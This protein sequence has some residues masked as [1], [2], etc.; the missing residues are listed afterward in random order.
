MK[1]DRFKA[2][3]PLIFLTSLAIVMLWLEDGVVAF[4][5]YRQDTTENGFVYMPVIMKPEN[6]TPTPEPTIQP[7]PT[8]RSANPNSTT[9]R[10][11]DCN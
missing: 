11:C 1:K 8:V 4:A 9:N 6:P 5:S 10:G 7:S 3:L 2:I